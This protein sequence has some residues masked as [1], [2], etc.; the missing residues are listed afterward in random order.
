M[1]QI[2]YKAV[3][4]SPESHYIEWKESWRDEYLKWICG[5]ANSKGGILVLGVRDDGSVC[6][7]K[8]APQLMEL[9]PNLV[10]DKLKLVVDVQLTTRNGK[11][12]IEIHVPRSFA[13][14]WFRDA[15][16]VRSGS[17]NQRLHDA[18]LMHFLIN[19]S[20]GK[21]DATTVEGVSVE[22]LDPLAFR[23]FR[24]EAARSRRL[25]DDDLALSNEELLKR[26]G[27][28]SHG[29]LTRAA[30]LLFHEN[31]ELW[32]MGAW[33]KIGFFSA[34]REE[35][36][37]HD[38]LHGSLLQQANA[39]IELIYTKYLKGII[40][41]EHDVRIETYP[42]SREVVREAVYN[43]IIHKD[44]TAGYPIQIKIYEDKLLVFNPAVLSFDWTTPEAWKQH[45]SR[46]LNPSIA[47][48]FF[49]IGFAESWGQGI[50]KMCLNSQAYGMPDPKYQI[51]TSSVLTHLQAIP[52]AV[53]PATE[54]T[55]TPPPAAATASQATEASIITLIRQTPT[56][57][58][59]QL[60]ESLGVSISTIERRV[61]ALKKQGLI[62]RAGAERGDGGEWQVK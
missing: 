45:G 1:L 48:T 38:E 25:S 62:L 27:L 33:V 51:D 6:G 19:K 13:P 40:S 29:K 2:A 3:Y 11:D 59:A 61:R 12:T 15:I 30:L 47:N 22:D 58:Q 39:V 49:R 57:T 43:A 5:F 35:V 17:T 20:G 52:A 16:Y 9:L 50:S 41:Y 26:L 46:P 44:Y 24:R 28:I 53:H 55:A 18:S 8:N 42:F 4:M 36:I 7:L 34:E 60:A 54:P 56:I 14:V 31:P 21:W 32:F 37:Y 23:I 10:R